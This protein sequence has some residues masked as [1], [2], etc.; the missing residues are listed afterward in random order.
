MPVEESFCCE[1]VFLNTP[2]QELLG[3]DGVRANCDH[4][5]E[6]IINAREVQPI[7]LVLCRACAGKAYYRRVGVAEAI[8][9]NTVVSKGVMST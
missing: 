4:C 7:G 1:E 6:E 3:R 9:S 5:G 8:L 2:V